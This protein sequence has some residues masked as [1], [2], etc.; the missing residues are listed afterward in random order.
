VIAVISIENSLSQGPDLRSAAAYRASRPFY[1]ALK[2]AYQLVGLTTATEEIARWWLK[3]E[4]MAEWALL[5]YWNEATSPFDHLE[6][7]VQEVREFLSS[8]WEISFYVDSDWSPLMKVLQL[9]VSTLRIEHSHVVPG[10]RDPE[11]T[12]PRPWSDI[13]ATVEAIHAEGD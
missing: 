10:W 8:G 12:A 13:A 5:R 4:H 2:G 3:R 9:G 7:K 1:E 11:T 6:W